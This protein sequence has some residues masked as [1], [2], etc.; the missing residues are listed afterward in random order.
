MEKVFVVT[1][2]LVIYNYGYET[3]VFQYVVAVYKTLESAIDYVEGTTHNWLRNQTKTG[4]GELYKM[5]YTAPKEPS[6]TIEGRE[7]AYQYQI[8]P[9]PYGEY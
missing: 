3:K 6:E 9:T 5:T 4:E 2:H 8:E 7:Y 1:K